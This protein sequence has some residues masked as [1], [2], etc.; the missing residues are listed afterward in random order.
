MNM[1]FSNQQRLI[2]QKTQTNKQINK[3][4]KVDMSLNEE[5]RTN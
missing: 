1:A 2:C 5:T 3:P 4:T